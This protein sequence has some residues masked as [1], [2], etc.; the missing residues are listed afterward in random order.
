MPCTVLCEYVRLGQDDFRSVE[1]ISSDL[2]LVIPETASLT[3]A[4]L[5]FLCSV[6]PDVLSSVDIWDEVSRICS[7]PCQIFRFSSVLQEV[8]GR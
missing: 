7:V 4:H 3:I 1:F 6:V 8:K 5:Q 2:T